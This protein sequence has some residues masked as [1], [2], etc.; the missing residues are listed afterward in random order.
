MQVLQQVEALSEFLIEEFKECVPDFTGCALVQKIQSLANGRHRETEDPQ[1]DNQANPF[2][3]S[4]IENAIVPR[5]PSRGFKQ[6][7]A[8][9]F[10]DLR[11]GYLESESLK[12][13]CGLPD[14][15]AA[16]P[17]RPRA[18][19]DELRHAIIIAQGSMFVQWLRCGSSPAPGQGGGGLSLQSILSR[20]V[21]TIK[22]IG[23]WPPLGRVDRAR[24]GGAAS[25]PSTPVSG[26]FTVAAF[27]SSLIGPTSTYSSSTT[28]RTSGA[29]S[30]I[31]EVLRER[32]F[33]QETRLRATGAKMA[34]HATGA[35]AARRRPLRRP[36]V[37]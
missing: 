7:L 24:P 34:D 36:P 25:I 35:L 8:L 1:T 23:L 22:D 9:E 30:P 14:R 13:L 16:R 12:T 19:K 11:R 2:E 17:R 32:E 4:V 28:G 21:P 6:T 5:C 27:S 26:S 10:A 20:I 3:A 15:P 18:S 29:A 31:P 33:Q 37:V